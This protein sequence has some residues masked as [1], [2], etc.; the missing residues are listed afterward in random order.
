MSVMKTIDAS[1]TCLI[2]KLAR[3]VR[4]LLD[5]FR[6]CCH[7][8]SF[9]HRR[10]PRLVCTSSKARYKL[11]RNET[12]SKTGRAQA[13]RRTPSPVKEESNVCYSSAYHV[14]GNSFVRT[15]NESRCNIELLRRASVSTNKQLLACRFSARANIVEQPMEHVHLPSSAQLPRHALFSLISHRQLDLVT[16]VLDCTNSTRGPGRSV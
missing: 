12:L 13:P 7:L 9:A 6:R 1:P 8:P 4:L 15:F 5:A 11:L 14:S 3:D 2:P 10:W 16:L